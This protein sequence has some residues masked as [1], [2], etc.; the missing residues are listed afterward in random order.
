[1]EDSLWRMKLLMV[2]A[3]T[4]VLIL[5]LM[6]D[7][8]WPAGT[9]V[10]AFGEWVVLILILMEDSLWLPE[11]TKKLYGRSSLNPYSNGR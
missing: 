2:A 4:A 10:A 11:I 3:E 1:M 8:L 6:E 7:S 9:M 5:I